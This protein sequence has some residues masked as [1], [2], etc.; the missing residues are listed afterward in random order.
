MFGSVWILGNAQRRLNRGFW[1]GSPAIGRSAFGAFVL[2]GLMLIGLAVVLRPFDVAAEVKALVV[3]A[4]GVAGS[5]ALARLL[6]GR[7]PGIARIL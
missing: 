7:V 3:A 4:G 1:W 5:F 2:Q 6:I